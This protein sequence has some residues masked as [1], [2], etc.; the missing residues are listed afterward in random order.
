M[1]ATLQVPF[2]RL[3]RW[4][5]ELSMLKA[6]GF[7]LAALTPRGDGTTVDEFNARSHP[8]RIAILVGTEGAGLSAAAE[9]IADHR[10]RIPISSR[11]DSLNL[12]VAAGIALSRLSLG[13][14]L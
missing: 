8:S 1:A 10:V 3:E 12:A 14:P 6:N 5:E 7:T 13:R 11:I 2:A 4:P 9:A